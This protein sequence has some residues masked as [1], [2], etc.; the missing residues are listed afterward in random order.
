MH[1]N[2]RKYPLLAGAF[3]ASLMLASPGAWPHGFAGKRFFPATLA[4]DN[5]FTSAAHE[6]ILSIR[7]G[8]EVGGTGDPRL[9]DPF[10]RVLVAAACHRLS[11]PLE[12]ADLY[13]VHR[14]DV[15]RRLYRANVYPC[16]SAFYSRASI[17]L[18]GYRPELHDAYPGDVVWVSFKREHCRLLYS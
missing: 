15:G 3:A 13:R 1:C 14:H 6:T 9:A 2:R 18:G 10:S 12:K 8:A 7:V 17:L 5:P 16:A 4:T 11:R